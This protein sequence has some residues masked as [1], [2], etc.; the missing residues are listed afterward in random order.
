[1]NPEQW[2]WTANGKE[3]AMAEAPTEGLRSPGLS[4]RKKSEFFAAVRARGVLN[5]ML[6]G[7]ALAFEK[8]NPGLFGLLFGLSTSSRS[9]GAPLDR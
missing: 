2:Q 9:R 1:M 5:T 7:P 3:G 4:D 6:D 8:S